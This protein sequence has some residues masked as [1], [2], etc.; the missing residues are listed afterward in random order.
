MNASCVTG[1]HISLQAPSSLLEALEEHLKS[2]ESS[3]KGRDKSV[4]DS[5]EL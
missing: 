2:L 5:L 1:V 4:S 3:K